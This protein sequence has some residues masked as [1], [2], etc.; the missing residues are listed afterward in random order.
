MMPNQKLG[1][2]M[3]KKPKNEPRLSAQEFGFAPA[4][5]PSGMPSAM[6]DHEREDG[7]LDRRRQ[8]F[9]DQAD[10]WIGIA[11]RRAE[12]AG[13][14]VGEK[15]QILHIDRLIEA[16]AVPG[17]GDVLRRGLVR[18]QE[19][20]R[21]ARRGVDQQEHQER[22]QHDRPGSCRRSGGPESGSSGRTAG[23]IA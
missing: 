16:P 9:A 6:R 7:E 15:S 11:E 17:V 4:H 20:G 12:I 8:A 13:D 18:Q 21:I 5:T 2:E 23:I 14:D 22:D 1:I 10:H 19:I 3:P